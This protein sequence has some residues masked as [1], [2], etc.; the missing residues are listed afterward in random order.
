MLSISWNF[1][2]LIANNHVYGYLSWKCRASIKFVHLNT[3][4]SHMYIH[5]SLIK[6]LLDLTY[7]LRRICSSHK[8]CV[9]QQSYQ[10]EDIVHLQIYSI[11]KYIQKHYDIN[12]LHISMSVFWGW[13]V[14]FT[15]AFSR[16]IYITNMRRREPKRYV[17]NSSKICRSYG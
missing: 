12:S 13:S 4:V 10:K 16:C 3:I 2:L 7:N 5:F 17:S 9:K 15:Y 6:L 11:S 1:K 14:G 8:S